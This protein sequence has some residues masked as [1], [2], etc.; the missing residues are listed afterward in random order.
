MN[1]EKLVPVGKIIK[2]HGIKGELKFFLYNND[3]SIFLKNNINIWLDF[4]NKF[5][6][7]E[8][9]S[10]KGSN[11][12]IIKIKKIDNRDA[13][14]LF[15]NKKL[16]ILRKDFPK[17]EKEN[18]YLNDI[19]NFKVFDN[20]KE[21]G[22][23]SDILSLPGGNIMVISCFGKEVLVPLVDKYTEFFDFDDNV[24]FMKNIQEFIKL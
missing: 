15:S 17:I 1:K 5:I 9:E 4:D 20:S 7:H 22:F 8:V 24:V 18:F 16:F 19:I 23:V 13:A 12:K 11:V 6:F 21:I 2:P 14:K 3:S 10:I